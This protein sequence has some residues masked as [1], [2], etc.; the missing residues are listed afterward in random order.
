[1]KAVMISL[2]LLVASLIVF[3]SI[4]VLL[5]S[6]RGTEAYLLALAT[7][8]NRTFGALSIS[9]EIAGSLDSL[10]LNFSSAAS[11]SNSIALAD[12]VESRLSAPE[13]LTPCLSPSNICRFVTVSGDT[14]LLVISDE[15]ASK[16]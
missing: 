2:D 1:M 3:P 13:N 9:Q 10:N 5:L 15:N 14:Y 4:G 8:Q 16:P 11:L 7:A 12:G 6:A